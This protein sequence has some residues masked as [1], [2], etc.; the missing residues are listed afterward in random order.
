MSTV[1][2]AIFNNIFQGPDAMLLLIA[3][4]LVAVTVTIVRWVKKKPKSS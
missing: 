4:L 2:L 3:V 1:Q